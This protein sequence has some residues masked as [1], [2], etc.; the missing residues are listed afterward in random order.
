MLFP[1]ESSRTL[2]FRGSQGGPGHGR[3]HGAFGSQR[4]S[5]GHYLGNRKGSAGPISIAMQD[6]VE[7]DRS[8]SDWRLGTSST[9]IRPTPCLE[10]TE[11]DMGMESV[12]GWGIA[13]ISNGRNDCFLQIVE[14]FQVVVA[15]ESRPQNPGAVGVRKNPQT[16]D[17]EV[18]ATAAKGRLGDGLAKLCEVG[19]THVTEKGESQMYLFRLNPAQARNVGSESPAKLGQGAGHGLGRLHSNECSGLTRH[20]RTLVGSD[21]HQDRTKGNVIDCPT[22]LGLDSS[23]V[24]RDRLKDRPGPL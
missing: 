8:R 19:V 24:H 22:C 4:G 18:E 12:V 3:I 16:L 6:G 21:F 15:E 1:Q 5:E 14:R 20:Q 11:G 7:I 10:S 23:L 13:C 9:N 17:A 2:T